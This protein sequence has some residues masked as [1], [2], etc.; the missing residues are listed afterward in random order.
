MTTTTVAPSTST[1]PVGA[2]AGGRAWLALALSVLWLGGFGSIAAIVMARSEQRRRR[3]AGLET[4]SI[5]T[6]AFV[7]GVLGLMACAFAAL[8]VV[9]AESRPS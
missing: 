9:G 8:L 5:A 3:G 2:K 1:R 6:A 4:S 7:I